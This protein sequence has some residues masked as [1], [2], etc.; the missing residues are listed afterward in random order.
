[1]IPIAASDEIG[2]AVLLPRIQHH[3]SACKFE[4]S[5]LKRL[6]GSWQRLSFA[7]WK[8]QSILFAGA[9]TLL[10]GPAQALD[11]FRDSSQDH[12]HVRFQTDL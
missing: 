1:M 9:G 11:R 6:C 2:H 4:R 5:A 12:G 8:T 10:R 7:D 3:A